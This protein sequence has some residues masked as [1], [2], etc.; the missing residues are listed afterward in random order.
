MAAENGISLHLLPENDIE[1]KLLIGFGEHGRLYFQD[2]SLRIDWT[3]K[4]AGNDPAL[5]GG[6]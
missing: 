5:G 4:G 2:R 6:K 3:F 1:R